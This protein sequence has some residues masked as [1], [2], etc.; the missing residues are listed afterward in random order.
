[1]YK[2]RI[3][4]LKKSNK[5]LKVLHITVRRQLKSLQTPFKQRGCAVYDICVKIYVFTRPSKV[6]RL[7]I[8]FWWRRLVEDKTK[9]A[10]LMR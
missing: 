3:L 10:S 2:L 8:P 4:N 7:S 9:P 6:L 5:S 1:M